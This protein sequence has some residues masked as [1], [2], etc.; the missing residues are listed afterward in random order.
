MDSKPRF[1]FH[2]TNVLI[3]F[4]LCDELECLNEILQGKGA[5]TGTI[6]RECN[7]RGPAIYGITDLGREAEYVLGD[8]VLPNDDDHV[9]IRQLRWEM[10]YTEALDADLAEQNIKNGDDKHLGEAETITI[11]QRHRLNAI[12]VTDDY[13]ARPFAE[14]FRCIDTWSLVSVGLKLKILDAARARAMRAQL[15]K[16]NRISRNHR[17]EIFNAQKFENW[18]SGQL[19]NE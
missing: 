6:R 13:R 7:G 8:P 10:A 9:Q 16:F 14:G 4:R 11:I 17:R 12:F 15:M 19:D 2:D 18:L 3:N 1:F 5:W